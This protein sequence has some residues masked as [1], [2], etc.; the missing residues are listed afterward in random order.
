MKQRYFKKWL[1]L[2]LYTLCCFGQTTKQTE[3]PEKVEQLKIGNFSLPPSQ[4]PGP[5][6]GFGQNIV[7]KGDLQA[8][9][10]GGAL[11]GHKKQLVE[12]APSILYAPRDDLSLFVEFPAAIQFKEN[13]YNSS[14]MEDIL[15]QLEYQLYVQ[16][17]EKK[18]NEITLVSNITIPTG[19]PFKIPPTGFGAPSIFLGFTASH[20]AIDW[21]Y[22]TSGAA[23]LPAR[24]NGTQFG[25]LF[26]Y[27]F[28]LS[29][30]ISYKPGKWIFNWMIELDG[31]YR[32]RDTFA[33]TIDFNTG[34]NM[35]VFGPSLWF[36]TEKLIV[37]GGFQW[38]IYQHNFG[39]QSK[40]R[41]LVA[42]NVAWTF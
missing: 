11:L 6:I 34:G 3:E 41:Y 21:Y 29:K 22:F 31:L 9:F 32:K 15:I 1:V 19:C 24:H 38:V 2:L 16:E 33:G 40:D 8:Y 17:T 10:F 36:S 25:K 28:G 26:L 42:V 12:A 7:N 39:I 13:N 37:Q 5:L 20:T 27:Q 4:Q 14:G 18:I 23:I 30:N 35:I